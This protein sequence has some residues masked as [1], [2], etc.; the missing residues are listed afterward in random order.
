MAKYYPV[1]PKFWR[2]DRRK[3]SDPTRLLALYLLTCEHR[4][5]EGL[6]YLP[7]PYVAADLAWPLEKVE[8]VLAELEDAAF[9]AY[10]ETAEVVLVP[11]ALAHQ[12]PKTPKQIA[13][14]LNALE[15][16]PATR[17]LGA[18]VEAC[19]THAPDLAD[20]IGNPLHA[21]ETTPSESHPD[22]SSYARAHI[23]SS[24]ST[25]I[26]P[27]NPPQQGGRQRD[28]KALKEWVTTYAAC[29]NDPREAEEAI[30]QALRVSSAQTTDAIDAHI[31]RWF[32]N[33]I[34]HST[35]ADVA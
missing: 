7:R 35:L 3:W 6:Y 14:A 21:V 32:P 5:L 22:G 26:N 18:F 8:A 12:T 19:R 33:L 17:L 23:S 27:P 10:D 16:V 11:K 13:G 34:K 29:F 28:K 20:A 15:A 24:N 4:N 1:F 31:A 2:G 30:K 25:S 9:C